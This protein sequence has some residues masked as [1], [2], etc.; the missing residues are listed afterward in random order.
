MTDAPVLFEEELKIYL[1]LRDFYRSAFPKDDP[2]KIASQKIVNALTGITSDLAR[3][4]IDRPALLYNGSLNFGMWTLPYCS[5]EEFIPGSD[6]DLIY[7]GGMYKDLDHKVGIDLGRRLNEKLGLGARESEA[8]RPDQSIRVSCMERI[9]INE[10]RTARVNLNVGRY[11]PEDLFLLKRFYQFTK[12][13]S[14]TCSE[15]DNQAAMIE[16]LAKRKSLLREELQK[17]YFRPL[18]S[19]LKESFWK[20]NHRLRERGIAVPCSVREDIDALFGA[21]LSL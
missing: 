16:T 21:Y 5:E 13:C 7:V 11:E 6:V 18:A 3:D 9:D 20:Y 14:T 15:S 8:A 4:G 17:P 12:F 19:E 1:R 2:S 10:L